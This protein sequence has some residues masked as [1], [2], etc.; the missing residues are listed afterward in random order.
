MDEAFVDERGSNSIQ[1]FAPE[2]KPYGLSYGEWTTKW[3]EWALSVPI[4]VNPV[5]DNTGQ[6]ADK[7][8]QNP[9]WFL[10]G[11]I[12]DEN[13]VA[14][15]TC[16][17]PK[18]N[19]ILFPVINYIHTSDPKFNTNIELV[20]HVKKDI[21]DIIINE[22]IVDDHQVPVYRV[23][24]E[25]RIFKLIVREENKLDIPVGITTASAD[26]YWVFLK[27]L[28]VGKHNIYFRGACSGGLRNASA[29]Y[30]II[31]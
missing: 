1:W 30:Q 29:Q 31:I 10:A 13:K 18:Q 22:A 17:I 8:Q 3:W 7:N 15:R 27:N 23:K 5:L 26:G 9:V 28:N 12:G 21:D 14:H 20:E 25:P 24:S 11:T 19:A 16:I 2:D 4:P 6:Y